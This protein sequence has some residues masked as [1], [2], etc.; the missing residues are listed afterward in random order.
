VFLF[1]LVPGWDKSAGCF[2]FMNDAR[3]AELLAPFLTDGHAA[4]SHEGVNQ[5]RNSATLSPDQLR[6]ISIYIDLLIRW[7][8]HF[9]LTA[10]RKPEEI[11]TRH[12]GESFF[13]ARR[14]FPRTH[15]ETNAA[16]PGSAQ[17][18]SRQ[19][20]IDFGSG[21]GFPGLPVKI[22]DPR[23]RLTLIEAN[24]KKATFLLEAVRS[25]KLT[26]VDVFA[27]RAEAFAGGKGNVVTF[28]AVERFESSLPLA[29]GLV[30]PSGRLA[31]LVGE[32]QLDR[33]R[34]L[35]PG[36][37]WSKPSPLPLSANRSM[38]IG[39]NEPR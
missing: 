17:A 9:N 11:V 39:V 27:G 20:V 36:F 21:A 30:V 34:D 7:N 24:Q 25:L 1:V 19:Q 38:I 31:V 18:E 6:F 29:A 26:D 8:A 15:K 14:L 23:I 33:V 16:D 5:P 28:R 12:F 32:A 2:N 13:A 4:R 10:V 22:W 3:I 37:M 35:A